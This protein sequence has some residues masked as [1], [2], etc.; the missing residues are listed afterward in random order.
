MTESTTS[1]APPR[2]RPTR[3]RLVRG[4]PMLVEGPVEVE[5]ADGNLTVSDRFLV[6]LCMCKRS[7][8]F[9]FCDASHRRRNTST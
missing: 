1:D 6:A 2:Q 7:K 5:D 8:Q 4:G 3:V 9:P